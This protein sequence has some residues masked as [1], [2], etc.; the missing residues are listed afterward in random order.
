MAVAIRQTN[1]I[2]MLFV[3]SSGIINITLDRQ[4]DKADVDDPGASI[5]KNGQEAPEKRVISGT[6]MRKRKIGV[7]DASE[8]LTPTGSDSSKSCISGLT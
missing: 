8:H 6:N 7:V 4:R 2:W 5:R 3:A 1:I